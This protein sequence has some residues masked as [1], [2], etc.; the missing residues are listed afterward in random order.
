MGDCDHRYKLYPSSNHCVG[1]H[2]TYISI[3]Y[4][5]IARIEALEKENFSLASWQCPY[6]D[7]KQ[8]LVGDEYGNQ[9]CAKQARIEALLKENAEL[10]ECVNA[11]SE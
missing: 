8:G 10:R 3:I 11:M 2:K 7:G 1:C 5:Q 4:E 9:Y 6:T